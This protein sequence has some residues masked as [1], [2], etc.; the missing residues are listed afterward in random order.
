[1]SNSSK[2]TTLHIASRITASFAGGY[3]FV[4]GI[5]TLGI[6]LA[7]LLGMPY[8]EAQTLLYMLAFLIY[9]GV[10]CWAYVASSLTKVW[11]VLAGGGLVMTILG[12]W[13][14]HLSLT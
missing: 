11:I 4:W 2:L 1:M 3:F 7:V 5:T 12:W 14:G 13:L 8:A 10:F 9:V 6:G